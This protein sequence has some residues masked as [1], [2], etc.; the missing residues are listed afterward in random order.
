VGWP[1]LAASGSDDHERDATD[2]SDA[3]ED[4]RDG[5]GA[6]LL[7]LDIQWTDFGVL[8]FVGETEAADGEA[9]DADE[10]ENGTDDGCGFH[11]RENLLCRFAH[12]SSA[13]A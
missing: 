9:D 6:G 1:G 8:M 12:F 11:G 5:D 3:A 10:D 13:V 4:R 7:V 2:E